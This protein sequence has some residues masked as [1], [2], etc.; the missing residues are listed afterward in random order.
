[1]TRRELRV[2]FQFMLTDFDCNGEG[3]TLFLRVSV[4]MLLVDR[5]L[6]GISCSSCA[7]GMCREFTA[8]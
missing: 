6:A 3:H 4:L 7:I 8:C 2:E 1:M 5:L